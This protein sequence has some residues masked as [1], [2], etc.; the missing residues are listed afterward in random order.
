MV[1]HRWGGL[2]S[3]T[4]GRGMGKPSVVRVKWGCFTLLLGESGGS[5]PYYLGEVSVLCLYYY[6]LVGGAFPSF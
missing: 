1:L 4:G 3:P 2:F 5:L 6:D